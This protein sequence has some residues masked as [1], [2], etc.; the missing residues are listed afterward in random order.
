[1][2]NKE[3]KTLSQ[4]RIEMQEYWKDKSSHQHED[5]K[6]IR[7]SMSKEAYEELVREIEHCDVCG[8]KLTK[9]KTVLGCCSVGCAS[10]ESGISDYDFI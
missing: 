3:N 2:M 7:A 6:E 5:D 1:M 10:E 4:S 8:V 9:G